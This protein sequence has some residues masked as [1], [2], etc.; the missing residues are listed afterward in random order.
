MLLH[1]VHIFGEWK[2]IKGIMYNFPLSMQCE[3]QLYEIEPDD[4]K[5]TTIDLE[6][7]ENQLVSIGGDSGSEHQEDLLEGDLGLGTAAALTREA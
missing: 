2:E 5:K 3:E 1:I 4:V 7:T 6:K